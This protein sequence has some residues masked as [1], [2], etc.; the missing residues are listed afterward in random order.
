MFFTVLGFIGCN[1]MTLSLGYINLCKGL[2]NGGVFDY[3][4]LG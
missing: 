4:T 1:L 3:K 2:S